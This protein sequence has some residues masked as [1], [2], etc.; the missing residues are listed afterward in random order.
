M[1]LQYILCGPH[2]IAIDP[3]MSEKKELLLSREFSVILPLGVLVIA[4]YMK[5]AF[6]T[7]HA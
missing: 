6:D 1:S 5:N 2:S 4:L 7:P 3:K